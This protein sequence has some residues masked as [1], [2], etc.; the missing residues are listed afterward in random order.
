MSE[1]WMACLD[2]KKM[3]EIPKIKNSC[4]YIER[5][6]DQETGFVFT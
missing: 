1:R 6:L 5:S 2:L 3:G 4:R